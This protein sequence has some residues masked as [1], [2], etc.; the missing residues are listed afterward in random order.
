[1]NGLSLMK[2]ELCK[3]KSGCPNPFS[4]F[5]PRDPQEYTGDRDE[6]RYLY[7]QVKDNMP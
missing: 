4:C 3:E 2:V 7:D 1:M 6:N 5:F